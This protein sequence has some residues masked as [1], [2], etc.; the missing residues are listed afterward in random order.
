ML[1]S[2]TTVYRATVA[3]GHT[4]L[5]FHILLLFRQQSCILQQ[6]VSLSLLN[7]IL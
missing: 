1:K 3:K 6:L 5:V 2:S 7:L 4:T